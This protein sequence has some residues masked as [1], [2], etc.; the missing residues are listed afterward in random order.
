MADDRCFGQLQ[1]QS[2]CGERC[3]CAS[4][5]WVSTAGSVFRRAQ[6]G[7]VAVLDFQKSTKTDKDSIVFT[8]NLGVLCGHI[9]KTLDPK[10][11]EDEVRITDCHLRERIGF[12]VPE[13]R[14]IWWTITA[15]TDEARYANQLTTAITQYVL[16]YLE[17]FLATEN[18]HQLWKSGSCPGLT[19]YQ[20]THFLRI[21]ESR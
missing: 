17:K 1:V 13:G 21:L 8:I 4:F 10:R 11:R 7:N 2:C 19:E 15:S 12:V 18:L 9:M 16:P 14:D 3:K 6:Q 20:R 5:T